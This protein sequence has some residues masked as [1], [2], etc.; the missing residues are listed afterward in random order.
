VL[1]DDSFARIK[2]TIIQENLIRIQQE[3]QFLSLL[4]KTSQKHLKSTL[5]ANT[6]QINLSGL[7][8]FPRTISLEWNNPTNLTL[9][10]YIYATGYFNIANQKT[11][12]EKQLIKISDNLKDVVTFDFPYETYIVWIEGRYYQNS[13]QAISNYIKVKTSERR[14]PTREYISKVY[15]SAT[16]IRNIEGW[17]ANAIEL[18]ATY[19]EASSKNNGTITKVGDYSITSNG[20]GWGPWWYVENTERSIN[21]VIRD[22]WNRQKFQIE[23]NIQYDNGIMVV[24]LREYDGEP[25]IPGKELSIPIKAVQH[26]LE[27]VGVSEGLSLGYAEGIKFILE[28]MY[29]VYLYDEYLGQYEIT[30]WTSN[31]SKMLSDDF[32]VIH[33]FE[34]NP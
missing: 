3:E 16:K 12:K 26:I 2:Q 20:G 5:N 11:F 10:Y 8:E 6:K 34:F 31:S 25:I 27:S 33:N 17:Y 30:W 15:I 32:F 29:K 1:P 28:S 9:R 19:S 24:Q 22:R 23:T 14:E 13:L 18:A 4:N 21:Y 7:S